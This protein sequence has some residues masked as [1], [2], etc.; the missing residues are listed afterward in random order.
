MC[1]LAYVSLL[2]EKVRQLE[3]EQKRLETFGPTPR[4]RF[5]PFMAGQ[6]PSLGE[7]ADSAKLR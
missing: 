4:G 5:V 1:D 7:S 6:S 2:C 3:I